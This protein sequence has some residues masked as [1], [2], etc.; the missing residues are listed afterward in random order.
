MVRRRNR[1]GIDLSGHLGKHLAEIT[2]AFRIGMPFGRSSKIVRID[3]AQRNDIHLG[4]GTERPKIRTSHPSNTNARQPK[5]IR[6]DRG[7]SQAACKMCSGDGTGRLR[8]KV[9]ARRRMILHGKLQKH[10][11][12]R[13][14]EGESRTRQAGQARAVDH[15]SVTKPIG[16]VAHSLPM[17]GKF[18]PPKFSENTQNRYP[19]VSGSLLCTPRALPIIQIHFFP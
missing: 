7:R 17:L 6:G 13:N 15:N 1:Y 4:V 3:I 2:K 10:R 19:R 8:K 14:G 16:P 5:S 18:V 12:D 11:K 9:S